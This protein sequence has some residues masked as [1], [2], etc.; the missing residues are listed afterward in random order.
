MTDFFVYDKIFPVIRMIIYIIRHAQ[1]VH[2]KIGKVFSGVSDVLL[3]ENGRLE[4]E[5]CRNFKFLKDVE[6]IYL[7]PLRR[8]G[9]TADIIFDKKIKRTI[10]SEFSEM[11]FGDYEGKILEED[12]RDDEVFQKWINDPESLTF[13]GGDNFRQ[14][15]ERAF[16]AFKRTAEKSVADVIAVVSHK[17]TIRLILTQLLGK[18]L[19]TFREI[20]CDNCSV[21]RVI[22]ENGR[23]SSDEINMKA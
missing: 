6:E 19:N 1:T 10:V 3:S 9:Q 15:A 17:T 7:S 18:P 20:P 14:H 12:S 5:K 21:T 2:N 16:D 11:N 8:A 22:Y 4:A 13:P 23:F